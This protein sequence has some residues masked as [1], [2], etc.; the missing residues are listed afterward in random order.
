M[1]TLLSSQGK[2]F[3]RYAGNQIFR[4]VIKE[5]SSTYIGFGTNRIAK[6]N[7][8]RKV[9]EN[10]VVHKNMRFV[11]YVK[12]QGWVLLKERDIKLKV[13]RHFFAMVLLCADLVRRK[14]TNVFLSDWPCSS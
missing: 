8:L 14:L 2:G 6:S 13:C 12:K 4:E 9:F 11:T 10:I 3:D 7:T 1:L 5:Y